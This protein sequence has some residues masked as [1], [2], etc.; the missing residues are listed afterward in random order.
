[1]KANKFLIAVFTSL[2]IF[3]YSCGNNN[4]TMDEHKHT[5][6]DGHNHAT[7]QVEE[8]PAG[9]VAATDRNNKGELVDAS[10]NVIVGC[11]MHK[12]MI[13]SEGDLCPKCNYMKM[14]PITWDMTGVDTVRV[15]TLPDY[16]PPKS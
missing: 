9:Q 15:T 1:M 3:I 8:Q 2:S 14:V 16:N 6:G 4:A 10:G 5:D 7:E 13:G 12:E 11:P